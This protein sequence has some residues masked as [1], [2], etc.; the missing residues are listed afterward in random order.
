MVPQQ[1]HQVV[2]DMTF[3]VI[4]NL[5]AQPFYTATVCVPN[6]SGGLI[7]QRIAS[8]ERFIKEVGIF[9]A[10]S[11]RARAERFVQQSNIGVAE[12]QGAEGCVGGCA[13]F[14]GRHSSPELIKPVFVHNTPLKSATQPAVG[15]K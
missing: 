14:P 15:F 5:A 10:S 6:I 12:E 8:F 9:A 11:R 7:N 1:C 13:E 4:I 2:R 3:A